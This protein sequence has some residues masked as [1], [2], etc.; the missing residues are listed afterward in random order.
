MCFS[1]VTV[2]DENTL[3]HL[4]WRI[5]SEFY[6]LYFLFTS[7]CKL[8]GGLDRVFTKLFADF[9]SPPLIWHG[10]V[11]GIRINQDSRDFDATR[12]VLTIVADKTYTEQCVP[13]V[14]H[15]QLKDSLYCMHHHIPVNQ[16][17]WLI[18]YFGVLTFLNQY[19]WYFI[20]G[21][22]DKVL[23]N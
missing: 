6:G 1:S 3:Y 4:K 13:R 15:D 16:S 17:T 18:V 7:P 20:I 5:F 14:S 12:S 10:D 9:G 21:T 19:I 11:V 22:C 2:I 8:A 23:L